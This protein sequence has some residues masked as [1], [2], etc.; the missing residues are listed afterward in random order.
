[1]SAKDFADYVVAQVI[2][3]IAAVFHRAW[4]SVKENWFNKDIYGNVGVFF[5]SAKF[6]G[7][8]R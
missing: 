8:I 4:F 1:M 5:Y 7:T 3:V 2:G 6:K